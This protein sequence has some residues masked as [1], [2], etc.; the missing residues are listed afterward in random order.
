MTINP[1]EITLRAKKLGVLLRDARKVTCHTIEECAKAIG[2]AP[3]E[4]EAFEFG[5]ASPSLPQ[6][7]LLAYFLR[8]PVEH[9]WSDHLL[10][11]EEK[12]LENVNLEFLMGLRQRMIGA[13]IRKMRM[14]KQF[15]LLEFAIRTGISQDILEDFELG[16]RAIPFA[17]L[18]S[19]ST[20][21]GYPIKDFMDRHGPIGSWFAEQRQARDFQG[22]SSELRDFVV[23]PV[24]FPYI[25]LAK[26]LSEM[27]VDRLRT[28]AETILEITY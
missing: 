12:S 17:E 16:K 5:E 27:N 28:I 7:E 3:G 6:L 8:I 26:R 13:T 15:T 10:P 19:I 4:Y 25:A 2:V 21:L 22:M 11:P 9:L 24:N 18:E 23:K 14:E 20:S 1:I